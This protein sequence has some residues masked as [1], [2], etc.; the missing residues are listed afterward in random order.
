[1]TN[2]TGASA[3]QDL[4]IPSDGGG[5]VPPINPSAPPATGQT[6]TLTPDML[7]QLFHATQPIHEPKTPEM[8]AKGHSAAPKF[9][10]E[11]A[12][13]ESYFTELEYQFDRCRINDPYDRKVQAVRYLDATPRRVWRGTDAFEDIDASWE[14]FKRQIAKM[15]PGS[16]T[17]QVINHS[18]ICAFVDSNATRP[19]PNEK[20]L[21]AYYRRLLSDTRMMIRGNRM[22]PREQSLLYL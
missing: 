9:D 10:D 8:P 15:Y 14:D 3:S 1:M 20:E 17:E 7:A 22:T 5:A 12:N 6:W 18:D 19:Y 11:P 4:P 2:P 16:G 21:G 13:L